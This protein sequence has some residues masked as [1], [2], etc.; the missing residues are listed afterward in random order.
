MAAKPKK[1]VM[2]LIDAL[3]EDFVEFDKD[4]NLFDIKSHTSLDT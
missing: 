1:V 4:E 2:M 3:R